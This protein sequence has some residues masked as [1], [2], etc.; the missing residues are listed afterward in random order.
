[1]PSFRSL[2]IFTLRNF[3]VWNVSLISYTLPRKNLGNARYLLYTHVYV[4]QNVYTFNS[5]SKPPLGLSKMVCKT[6]FEEFQGWNS[7]KWIMG[8]GNEGH[9]HKWRSLMR[10]KSSRYVMCFKRK[11]KC[12]WEAYEH[13]KPVWFDG[14]LAH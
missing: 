5:I 9:R 2:T 3:S 7:E 12:A 1:M 14:F 13:C 6:C 8:K 11:Y 10:R 4:I